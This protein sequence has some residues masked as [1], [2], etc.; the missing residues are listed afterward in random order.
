MAKWPFQRLSDLH[1]GNQKVSMK[2]LVGVISPVV[3]GEQ[4]GWGWWWW[5]W[6]WWW[7]WWWC[8]LWWWSWLY[9]ESTT[10]RKGVVAKINWCWALVFFLR[11]LSHKSVHQLFEGVMLL[12]MTE[13]IVFFL[14]GMSSGYPPWLKAQILKFRFLHSIWRSPTSWGKCTLCASKFVSQMDRRFTNLASPY[15]SLRISKLGYT[16]NHFKS[17]PG[18]HLNTLSIYL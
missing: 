13:S 4:G 3:P 9:V 12:S 16:K 10:W 7:R 17:Q 1:P 2:H 14:S 6:W 15:A 8:W 18:S 11:Y 5:W